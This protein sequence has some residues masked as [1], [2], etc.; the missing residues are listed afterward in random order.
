MLSRTTQPTINRENRSLYT[1]LKDY[2]FPI[3]ETSEKVCHA[4]QSSVDCVSGIILL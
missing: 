4:C 3:M 1:P 2:S